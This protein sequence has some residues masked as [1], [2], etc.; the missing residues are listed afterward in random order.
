[1]QKLD[2]ATFIANPGEQITFSLGATGQVITAIASIDQGPSAPLPVTVTDHHHVM[3][4]VT[5]T[6]NSGGFADINIRS[7]SGGN[8][9]DRIAQAPSI[10]FRNREYKT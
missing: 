5:F 3:I 1:M 4:T 2:A 8:D 7:S 6:G 10:G 9:S